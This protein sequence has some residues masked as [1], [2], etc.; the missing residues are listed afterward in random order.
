M[1]GSP[2]HAA[3]YYGHQDMLAYLLKKKDSMHNGDSLLSERCKEA[4]DMQAKKKSAFQHE[5]KDFDVLMLAVVGVNPNVE[6]IK[7]LLMAGAP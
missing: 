2:I 1:S 5:F 4:Q 6:V 3:A 7:Q